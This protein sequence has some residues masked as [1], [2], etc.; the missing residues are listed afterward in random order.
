LAAVDAATGLAV[1]DVGAGPPVLLVHGQPGSRADWLQLLPLLTDT[2][3]VLSVDR[4][5]Y[6]ASAGEAVGLLENADLLGRLLAE[7]GALGATVVGHSL[8]AGIALAM[9]ERSLGVGALV[10]IG[11][12]GVEGTV[13]VL[14]RVLAIRLAST[15]GIT[16]VRRAVRALGCRASGPL[17]QV[18]DGWGPTSGRSFTREQRALLRERTVLEDAL[19]DISVPTTVVVGGRDR[20]VSPKAQR[21]LAGRIAGARLV[22]L[23]HAGH[24]IPLREP[25]RLAEIARTASFG[26]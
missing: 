8:G 6:G 25:A 9:A 1:T 20:V 11:P 3:R 15:I 23:P 26:G 22:E 4:P 16:G 5:G 13:G 2:H 21:A 7:R 24:L 14:D 17:G 12:A 18:I 10:L 19:D